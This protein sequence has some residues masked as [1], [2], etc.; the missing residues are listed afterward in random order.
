MQGWDEEGTVWRKKRN[1]IKINEA[2]PQLVNISAFDSDVNN[3]AVLAVFKMS[4]IDSLYIY[5]P[6][7]HGSTSCGHISALNTAAEVIKSLSPSVLRGP[8]IRTYAKKGS[9]RA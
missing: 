6:D 4:A 8:E 3:G 1:C 2:T 9:G 5:S 7:W